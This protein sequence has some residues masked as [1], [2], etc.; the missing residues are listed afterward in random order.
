[1][2]LS[3]MALTRIL[4]LSFFKNGA[5]SL[6]VGVRLSVVPMVS[7]MADALAIFTSE[8]LSAEIKNSTELRKSRRWLAGA[9]T[10]NFMALSV[11]FSIRSFLVPFDEKVDSALV[12]ISGVKISKGRFTP[13]VGLMLIDDV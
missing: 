2:A 12:V 4:N 3:V 8:R 9:V 6:V 11:I 10:F 1:M 13:A 7:G 5:K